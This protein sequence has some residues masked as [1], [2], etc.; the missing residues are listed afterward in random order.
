MFALRVATCA[1]DGPL[2]SPRRREESRPASLPWRHGA[3]VR[4]APVPLSGFA[5]LTSGAGADVAYAGRLLTLLGADVLHVGTAPAWGQLVPTALALDDPALLARLPV[6][7]AVDGANVLGAAA[8]PVVA[9]PLDAHPLRDWAASGAMILTGDEAGPPLGAPGWAATFLGGSALAAR[10]LARLAGGDL[11]VDGAALVG[12]RAA[13]AGLHRRGAVSVGGASRL[14]AAADGLVAVSL[15]RPS[16]F[17]ALEAWVGRPPAND[18]PWGVVAVHVASQSSAAAADSAQLLGLAVARVAGPEEAA[19]DEQAAARAQVWPPQ[20]WLINGA[21]SVP[22]NSRGHAATAAAPLARTSALP[23]SRQPVARAAP[24]VVD[25]TSLWAGPLCAS[26][27]GLAGARVIKVETVSRPDGTR[28][29][30]PEFFDL[31]NA[32][33][34]S[35]AIDERTPE[36]RADLSCLLDAA[37]IVVE[38]ARPR[39]MRQ[40][41]FDVEQLVG[42][43]RD[44]AWVSITAYG[45]T[46]PWQHRVGF[47]DD[48]AAAAGFTATTAEGGPCFCADAYADPVAGLHAAVAALAAWVGGGAHLVDVSLREV[49]GHLLTGYDRPA[50][51]AVVDASPARART[52]LGHGPPRGR[53]TR[54][55]LA[56]LGRRG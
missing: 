44:L 41:G 33:K 27:L 53:D 47:G 6:A 10:L 3:R 42:A 22:A 35:V 11:D 39:V 20:P 21:P 49:V 17:D 15:T 23:V 2:A 38:A 24:L 32:G 48:T 37:D 55:I 51:P 50:P 5:F 12:E 29:G 18:D 56:E 1:S 9:A 13:I 52:P 45:R 25:L 28:R 31:L 34:T 8:Y 7:G 19:A 43:R 46:G 26:L 54:R 40:W 36:G 4:P 14:L 16:D 30:P